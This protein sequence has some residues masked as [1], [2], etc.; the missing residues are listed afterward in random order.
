MKKIISPTEKINNKNFVDE[1]STEDALKLMINDQSKVIKVLNE[2]RPQI[3]NITKSIFDR[4][5]R[6][7]K[8]RKN[9]I[10]RCTSGKLQFKM[11]GI[12]SN[13]WLAKRRLD[14][15]IAGGEKVF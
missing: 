5:N 4:L 10:C 12:I 9:N 11:E 14:F 15:I 1:M 3:N 2:L 13:V 8:I 6:A 7:L